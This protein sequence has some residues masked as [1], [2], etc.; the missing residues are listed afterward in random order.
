MSREKWVTPL[1]GQTNQPPLRDLADHSIWV[2]NP[3]FAMPPKEAEY[4]HARGWPSKPTDAVRRVENNY[5]LPD[6]VT[7]AVNGMPTRRAM[8]WA[9]DQVM[10]GV[11]GQLKAGG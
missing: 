5:V 8:E 11:R 6:M 10:Q 2:K 7:K 4:V 3:K 1:D 9:Q